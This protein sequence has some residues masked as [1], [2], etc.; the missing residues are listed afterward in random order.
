MFSLGLVIGD[1]KGAREFKGQAKEWQAWMRAR[2]V[3]ARLVMLPVSTL[4]ILQRFVKVRAALEANRDQQIVQLAI[5]CHG[6][7]S[8]IQLVAGE[9]VKQF[10]QAIKA[11]LF[12]SARVIVTLYCCTAGSDTDPKTS[13]TA[14]N[15]APGGD[16]GFADLLRDALCAEGV[17][18]CRVDAHTILGHTTRNPFVRRFEGRGSPAGGVGGGW[19]VTPQ[20]ALWHAWDKAVERQLRWEF[21]LLEVGAIH[22]KLAA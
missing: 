6:W 20:S 14:A 11:G 5:F 7:S 4:P 10:A 19:L 18:D 3:E 17:V 22:T 21:P 12:G 2:G 13:E 15:D 16:G 8:G 9:R 1:G